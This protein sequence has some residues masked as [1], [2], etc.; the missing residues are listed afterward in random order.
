MKYF[1]A[2]QLANLFNVSEFSVNRWLELKYI[3]F[4]LV[5]GEIKFSQ[6]HI[7]DFKAK[8]KLHGFQIT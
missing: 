4:D 1:N 5:D 3:D 2:K 6:K 8:G 7:E